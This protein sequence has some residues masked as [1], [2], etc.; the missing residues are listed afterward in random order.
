MQSALSSP[1]PIGGRLRHTCATLAEA[2]DL[3]RLSPGGVLPRP[4]EVGR[5]DD[6]EMT[7]TTVQRTSAGC[8]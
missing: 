2:R 8:T 5:M 1:Q 3:A 6:V 7:H 4:S